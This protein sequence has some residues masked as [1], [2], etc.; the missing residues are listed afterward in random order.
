[1][2]PDVDFGPTSSPTLVTFVLW[3]INFARYIR[4]MAFNL[5]HANV[6][7]RTSNHPSRKREIWVTP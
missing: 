2:N 6:I 4:Y 5:R 7:I 1:M 3:K